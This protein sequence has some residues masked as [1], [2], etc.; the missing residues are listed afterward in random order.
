MDKVAHR[1]QDNAFEIIDMLESGEVILFVMPSAEKFILRRSEKNNKEA[2]ILDCQDGSIS[3]MH[4]AW[5]L[6]DTF[7]RASCYK[8]MEY[9]NE[10]DRLHD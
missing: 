4:I 1:C 3:D 7:G 6:T 8:D 10:V 9:K 5:D 2:M